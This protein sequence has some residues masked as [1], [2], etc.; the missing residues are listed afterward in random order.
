MK[1]VEF[2]PNRQMIRVGHR[3]YQLDLNLREDGTGTA[4]LSEAKCDGSVSLITAAFRYD[5]SHS[6]HIMNG[7]PRAKLVETG[8]TSESYVGAGKEKG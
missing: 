1:I 6:W 2:N 3:L 4:R 8:D 5:T 7:T